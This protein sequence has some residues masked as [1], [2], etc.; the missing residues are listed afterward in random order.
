MN[1]ATVLALL[2]GV[3]PIISAAPQF[4]ALFDE[5]LGTFHQKDQEVLKAAYERAVSLADQAHSDLQN[6]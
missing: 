6:V 1:I 2:N 3:G 4:K 5:I